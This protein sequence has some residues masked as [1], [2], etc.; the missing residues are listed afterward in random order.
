MYLLLMIQ[1]S[2]GGSLNDVDFFSAILKIFLTGMQLNSIALNLPFE[3]K[4][5][6]KGLMEIQQSLANAGPPA[7]SI[8]CAVI[9]TFGTSV[10]P[11]F[12]KT[13]NNLAF[14]LVLVVVAFIFAMISSFFHKKY[15]LKFRQL[16]DEGGGG[17]GAT[18]TNERSN[19]PPPPPAAAA[20]SEHSTAAALTN[21]SNSGLLSG[22]S[23]EANTGVQTRN[24]E[25]AEK[26]ENIGDMAALFKD[27]SALYIATNDIE[28]KALAQKVKIYST[29]TFLNLVKVK[30]NKM[31]L[32]RT[33]THA[34][35]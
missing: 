24:A 2:L 25:S 6:A 32:R 10:R 16:A 12:L 7:L 4:E 28:A 19:L 31:T 8:D 13:I 14:P 27:A 11:F 1:L 23:Q 33:R 17:G 18:A 3:W 35:T 22:E 9:D 26:D 15:F 20:A 5:P 29:L 30:H 34:R 21:G